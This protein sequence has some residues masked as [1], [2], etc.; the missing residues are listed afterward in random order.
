MPVG[1]H[2]RIAER[3]TLVDSNTLEFEILTVAPEL[4]TAP[5]KRKRTYSR[6][7]KQAANEITLCSDFDR[8]IDPA[9][10][11]QRFDMTPPADLAPPPAQ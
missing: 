9:T 3:I 1:N 6:V 10:G 7:P 5:D 11:K 2:V 8:A 4:F